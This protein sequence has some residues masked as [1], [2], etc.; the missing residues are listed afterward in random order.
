LWSALNDIVKILNPLTP[1]MQ[2]C[3]QADLFAGKHGL[4]EE[5]SYR[6]HPTETK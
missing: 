6:F 3:V 2:A 1:K 5:K 4:N